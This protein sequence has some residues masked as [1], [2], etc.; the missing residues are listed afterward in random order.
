MAISP[1]VLHY[2]GRVASLSRER[3]DDDPELVGARL[4]LAEAKRISDLEKAIDRLTGLLRPAAV[5]AAVPAVTRQA[6]L[7]QAAADIRDDDLKAQ[8][9]L[10]ALAD[11][12]R[13]SDLGDDAKTSLLEVLRAGIGG[14]PA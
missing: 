5:P 4:G 1:D 3:A 10:R 7:D 14:A 6:E 13:G 8:K 12:I 2:R 11:V 9:L